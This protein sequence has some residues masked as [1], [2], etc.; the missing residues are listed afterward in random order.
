[1]NRLRLY[2]DTSVISH[3]FHEDA[4]ERQA[5]TREL[6]ENAIA[7]SLHE[8]FVSAVVIDELRRTRDEALRQRLLDVLVA[9]PI[10][11]LPDGGEE[12]GRLARAYMEHEIV[13]AR[14]P[15]DA[16]HVAYATHFELDVLV[17]WNYRHLARART[18]S[19][20]ASVNMVEGYPRPLQILTPLEVLKP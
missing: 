10:L 16:L 15:E 17:T 7:P 18:A 20:V 5:D 19:L 3:L 9:Y 13:P 12:V 8:T 11:L 6:F 4:P 2:L 14:N 1:L